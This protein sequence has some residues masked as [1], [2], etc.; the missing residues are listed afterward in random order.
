[1]DK[2]E[3]GGVALLLETSGV[4]RSVMLLRHFVIAFF[5]YYLFSPSELMVAE[6][7]DHKR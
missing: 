3:L 1:M 6:V 2:G 4:V 7:P 5:S